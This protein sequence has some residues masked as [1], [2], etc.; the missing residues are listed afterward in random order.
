MLVGYQ[1]Q[2]LYPRNVRKI[3]MARKEL[4]KEARKLYERVDEIEIDDNADERKCD[5]GTWVQAWVWVPKK[6][7]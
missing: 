4:V 1:A 3:R 5:E 2:Q 7:D 6:N